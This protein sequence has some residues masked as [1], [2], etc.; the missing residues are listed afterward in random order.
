MWV[1]ETV[2]ERATEPAVEVQSDACR[3]SGYGSY[4]D[5]QRDKIGSWQTSERMRSTS[6]SILSPM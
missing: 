3:M 1:Q 6:L 5:V 2:R 4:R